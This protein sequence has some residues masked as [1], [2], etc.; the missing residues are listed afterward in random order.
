MDTDDIKPPAAGPIESAFPLGRVCATPHA[1]E[2]LTPEEI[3]RALDRHAR[4]DW[5]ELGERDWEANEEAL[6][7]GLRLFSAYPAEGHPGRFWVITEA[8]RSAT[9]VLMPGDY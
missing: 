5:G 3:R 2:V 6:E 1:L 8:D 4:G 7:L 9:T